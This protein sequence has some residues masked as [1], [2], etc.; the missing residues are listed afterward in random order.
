VRFSTLF[1]ITLFSVNPITVEVLIVREE[2][3]GGSETHEMT[4]FQ[5]YTSSVASL[6]L[7]VCSGQNVGNV[8][9]PVVSQPQAE[10]VAS[11]SLSRRIQSHLLLELIEYEDR[12]DYEVNI[13]Q[14]WR[15]DVNSAIDDTTEAAQGWIQAVDSGQSAD[16]AT[17]HSTSGTEPEEQQ[18][19]K[20]LIGDFDVS[21][22]TLWTLYGKE[23]KSYDDARINT[24]KDDMDGVLIFVRPYSIRT[25]YEF[26][27]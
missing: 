10:G 21:A 7:P 12:D 24:L 22:N 16:S 11:I 3:V 18:E 14:S 23:A 5:P 15:D 6:P 2:E 20:H 1:H 17:R 13:D 27:H 9:Q 19:E 4:T 8:A 26:S 25:Y